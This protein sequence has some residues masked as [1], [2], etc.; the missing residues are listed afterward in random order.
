MTAD[1][2][3]GHFKQRTT[4]PPWAWA[5]EHIDYSR[6]RS[7]DTPYRGMFDPEL[8]PF[9]NE[10][11]ESA[12]DPAVREIVCLKCSRAGYSENLLLTDLRYTIDQAP[13]P[14]LYVT[15]KMDLAKGFLDRRVT[16][17]M[18]LAPSLQQK[19]KEAKTVATDIQFAEMDFRATWSTSDTATKQD[20]WARIFADEVSLWGEFTVDMLRRRC[21]A[22]P[23]HHI[24]FG[25]SIDPTRRGNPA[26]DPTLKLYEESDK[27]V[28]MMPDPVTGNLFFWHFSGVKWDDSA[29]HD[30]EWD[31]RKVEAGAWYETPDGTRID[32]ADRMKVTRSGRWVVTNPEG[33]RRGYKVVAPMVPFNDCGF[34]TLAARFLSAKHRM[35]LTGSKH[36][37]QRNTLRT[38][39]AE[40][41]AEAH[42]DEAMVA[43]D[44]TLGD[45][46]EE[47]S[48]GTVYVPSGYRHCINMTVDVQKHHFWH[49]ARVWSRHPKSGTVHTSLLQYDT[50]ATMLDIDDVAK[51]LE[52]DFMG[53]DISYDLR[54]T[55]VA[56]YCSAFTDQ[57]QPRDAHVIA[58]RGS[59]SITRNIDGTVDD[60]FEG[61]RAAGRAL[62]FTLKWKV[63]TFRTML[64]DALNGEE[65]FTWCVPADH[66]DESRWH[67]HYIKQVTSTKKVDG[68]WVPPGHGQDH[69]FD[70]EVMQMVLA[71]FS[72][73][74]E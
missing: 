56:R 67:Q 35:N 3:V 53:L 23:F 34:G 42:Q 32:E 24:I 33:I 58:L 31:L 7:Y 59:D 41:W 64:L 36:D 44:N 57:A 8:M 49:V 15:G 55:E 16:R 69:L 20:G 18:T 9:W 2:L 40:H 25:G 62:Y 51:Q 74:I 13:E 60:A 54:A 21:A 10:I 22:Y 1:R 39:F 50:A 48:L 52:L 45:R 63:D 61:F 28:W 6:S 72:G 46:E 71:Q 12:H 65:D 73:I 66:M 70:C 5:A 11:L 47:Y 68:V 27:R 30:D 38:Y 37:R 17:G 19:L 43:R 4:Q 14:T 26:E 29:K